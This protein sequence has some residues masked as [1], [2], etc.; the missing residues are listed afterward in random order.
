MKNILLSVY[1]LHK[2]KQISV[3]QLFETPHISKLHHFLIA[4]RYLYIEGYF[5]KNERKMNIY[6]KI[7]KNN[8]VLSIEERCNMFE[9][10]I[11]SIEAN[12]FDK[13][14]PIYID[15]NYNVFNGTHR[16]ATAC[17]FGIDKIPAK[18]ILRKL[19]IPPVD[20]IIKANNLSEY[21]IEETNKAYS[22]M[23]TRIIN[24]GEQK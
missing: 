21:E 12:G 18:K 14:H 5:E 16:I 1:K 9:S 19:R 4:V 2:T 24:I 20:M 13:E 11:S 6:K 7:N 10:L 15:Y 17:Y 8:D 3:I 23:Y 22:R